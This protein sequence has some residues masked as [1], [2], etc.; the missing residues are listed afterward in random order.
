MTGPSIPPG[1]REVPSTPR[2]FSA[3]SAPHGDPSPLQPPAPHMGTLPH[4]G[5][6]YLRETPAFCPRS[7]TPHGASAPLLPPSLSPHMGALPRSSHRHPHPPVELWLCPRLCR[8][9]HTPQARTHRAAPKPAGV[10]RAWPRPR[11]LLAASAPP[12]GPDHNSQRAAR[13]RAR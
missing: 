1:K 3:C 6:R 4:C 11:L 5:P 12:F 9:S 8:G 2:L 7:H 13:S 10:C